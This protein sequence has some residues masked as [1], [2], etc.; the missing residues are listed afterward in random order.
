MI[1]KTKEHIE[2][3]SKLEVKTPGIW[4]FKL[5]QLHDFFAAKISQFEKFLSDKIGRKL[6]FNLLILLAISFMPWV[7]ETS[8]NKQIYAEIK[9][10]S[11]PLDPIRAGDLTRRISKY[12]PGLKEVPEDV[13]IS[14]MIKNDNYTLAQQLAVNANKNIAVAGRQEATYEVRAGETIGQIAEKFGLHVQS[15][16]DANNIKAEEAKNIG[17]GLVLKIPSSDTSTSK[18]WMVAI[19]RAEDEAKAKAA[20][21]ATKAAN[22]AAK[23][24]LASSKALATSKR[25][26]SGYS[27][28][29]NSGL[30]TPISGRGISQYFG[31]GHT[32]VDYMASVGTAVRAAAGGKVVIMS[33]GWSGG[34]GNQIVIDHGGGR[35]TRYAH[36]SSFNVSSGEVV[37]KGQ[38]IAY[39]GNTGRST[40]PH[41]HFELIIGG[42]PVNPL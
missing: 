36:L 33:S 28:V 19:K 40:G 12:T 41:L 11:E 13:T 10:Y 6:F 29:D 21:E 5:K 30:I 17:E 9:K 14:L 25:S 35:A 16:L 18:D 20:E 22:E 15:I 37:S 24:R 34:Y 23:R 32:G 7:S 4:I 38:T 3:G 42:R 39:S 26:S 8:V 2:E 27:S 31:R 1:N